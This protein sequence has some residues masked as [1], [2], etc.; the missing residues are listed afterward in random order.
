MAVGTCY[1]CKQ[2]F[3]WQYM[4]EQK[5]ERHVF[6]RTDLLKLKKKVLDMG[7]DW[8]ITDR[9]DARKSVKR[10]KYTLQELE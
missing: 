4:Y 2:G 7:L 3:V 5:G 6:A 10:T 9:E 8:H 1:G